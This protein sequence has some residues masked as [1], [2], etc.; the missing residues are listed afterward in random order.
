MTAEAKREELFGL[1]SRKKEKRNR[2]L[3]RNGL[4]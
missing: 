2:D 4:G 1:G 3:K